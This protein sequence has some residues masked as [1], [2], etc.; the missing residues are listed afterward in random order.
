MEK[1]ATLETT[2]SPTSPERNASNSRC[3]SLT[4][5]SPLITGASSA[6]ASSSSWSMYCPITSVGWP[7]VLLDQPLDHVDLV[8]GARRQP[9]ALLRLGGRVG[10]PLG[11][12]SVTRTSTQSAGAM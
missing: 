7:G 2:S 3:R 11:V 12:G 5:V 6:S 9:V 10:Q 8:V 4:V 1:F